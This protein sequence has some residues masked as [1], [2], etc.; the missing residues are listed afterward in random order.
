M[1]FFAQH[2]CLNVQTYEHLVEYEHD[3]LTPISGFLFFLRRL[4]YLLSFLYLVGTRP[5]QVQFAD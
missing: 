2:T 4:L 1:R 5:G 3:S